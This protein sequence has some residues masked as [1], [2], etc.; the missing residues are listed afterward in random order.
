M[1]PTRA[2]KL[3]ET[4]RQECRFALLAFARLRTALNEMDQEWV[5]VYAQAMLQ[6]AGQILRTGAG[7][8]K[9]PCSSSFRTAR[10]G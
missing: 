9:T 3:V 10:A 5:F 7:G 2:F 4:V 8:R 6:H 1:N